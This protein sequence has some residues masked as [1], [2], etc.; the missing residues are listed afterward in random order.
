[1]SSFWI[2]YRIYCGGWILSIL[3]ATCNLLWAQVYVH[4]FI[5]FQATPSFSINIACFSVCNIKNCL[6]TRLYVH[7]NFSIVR[8]SVCTCMRVGGHGKPFDPGTSAG[9]YSNC[10]ISIFVR[11]DITVFDIIIYWTLTSN[12]NIWEC[13]K[14]NTIDKNPYQSCWSREKI[15]ISR[16][17]VSYTH[18]TLPTIYSV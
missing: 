10:S 9:R 11:Q 18:L 17:A 6:G 16:V 13:E 12:S 7:I 4:S 8:A 15:H 5:N 2:L 14:S 1:M 3:P